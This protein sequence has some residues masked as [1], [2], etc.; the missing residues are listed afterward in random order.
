MER[1]SDNDDWAGRP[2]DDLPAAPEA[3]GIALHSR[4]EKSLMPALVCSAEVS[5]TWT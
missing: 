3:G 1:V 5:A 4:L 2:V